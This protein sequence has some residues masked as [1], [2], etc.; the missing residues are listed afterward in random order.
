MASDTWNP[1]R[2]KGLRENLGMTQ[3]RFAQEVGCHVITVIR[4]EQGKSNPSLMALHK[5]RQLESED[6]PHR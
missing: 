2:I 1:S 3:K 4:W 6:R 5:L